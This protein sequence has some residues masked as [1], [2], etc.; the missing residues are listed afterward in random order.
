M[1]ETKKRLS[2]D[3]QKKLA[4]LYSQSEQKSV[5]LFEYPKD[6][7]NFTEDFEFINRE[8]LYVEFIHFLL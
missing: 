6:V 5:F 1:N 7:F 8:S 2:Y 3:N 4:E